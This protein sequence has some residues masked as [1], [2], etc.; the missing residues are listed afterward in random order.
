MKRNETL[1]TSLKNDRFSVK[2]ESSHDVYRFVDEETGKELYKWRTEFEP[3]DELINTLI[4][5]LDCQHETL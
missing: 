2:V 4:D 1:Y 3:P 5:A